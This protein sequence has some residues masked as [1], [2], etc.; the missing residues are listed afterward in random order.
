MITIRPG[1]PAALL[2]ASI[3]ADRHATRPPRPVTKRQGVTAELPVRFRRP[4]INR[5]ALRASEANA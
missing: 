4:I 2:V 3:I 1:S 5:Q